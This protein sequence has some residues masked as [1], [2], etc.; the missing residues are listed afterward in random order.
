MNIHTWFYALLF[1]TIANS[2]SNAYLHSAT[3]RR[4]FE[5]TSVAV[6]LSII[7]NSIDTRSLGAGQAVDSGVLKV[8]RAP[9]TTTPFVS[10]STQS[11]ISHSA[12][13]YDVTILGGTLGIVLAAS[14]QS[15]GLSVCVVERGLVQGRDQDW[16]IGNNELEELKAIMTDEQIQSIPFIDYEKTRVKF[17]SEQTHSLPGV[18][19]RGISPKSLISTIRSNFESSGGVV[20]ESTSV[21]GVTITPTSAVVQAEEDIYI[22]SKLVVDCMGNGS[23][24]SKQIRGDEVANGVC[25]VVGTQADGFKPEYRGA[26][27]IVSDDDIV[28]LGT[29]ERRQYFWESFPNINGKRTTYLFTY[30]DDDSRRDGVESVWNDYVAMLPGY[31]NENHEGFGEGKSVEECMDEGSFKP[32][33][34]F[35]GVFKTFKNSPIQM[36]FDRIVSVGDASGVQSPLSF[37]GFGA[38]LRHLNR[39][40]DSLTEAISENVTSKNDLN[41]MNGYLPNQACTWMFQK[42]MSVP[43]DDTR[44]AVFI[45]RLMRNNYKGMMSSDELVWKSFNQDVVKPGP[46]LKVITMATIIDPLNIPTLLKVVGP[47]ELTEWMGHVFMMTLYNWLDSSMIAPESGGGIEGWRNRRKRELWKYGSGRDYHI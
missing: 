44:D 24:I 29:G 20:H 34:S 15:R 19:N 9:P 26:D 39:Y 42:S 7:A 8:N 22:T 4:I 6:P 40:S 2:D 30:L 31:M 11:Q 1:L 16:N 46:L 25:I 27:L 12:P 14:L 45:N 43:M 21:K 32:A 41:L 35:T 38:M 36:D 28:D 23:P 17:N 33:K 5:A 18:L 10:V 13:T 37:G 47:K 3:I